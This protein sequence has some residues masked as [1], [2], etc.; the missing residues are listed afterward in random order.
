MM[1]EGRCVPAKAFASMGTRPGRPDGRL[2]DSSRVRRLGERA[3]MSGRE[4]PA[5]SEPR[6]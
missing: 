6:P 5:S 4:K 3:R 1:A 2:D